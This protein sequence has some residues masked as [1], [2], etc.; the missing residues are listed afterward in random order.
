MHAI[1]ATVSIRLDVTSKE[2]MRRVGR[3]AGLEGAREMPAPPGG[4]R[5][6]R[7]S[8]EL[9]ARTR[10]SV[11]FL[12]LS[13]SLY[14][15]ILL[16]LSLASLPLQP[17]EPAFLLRDTFTRVPRCVRARNVYSSA[18]AIRP[19]GDETRPPIKT[20]RIACTRLPLSRGCVSFT[21]SR[22]RSAAT[23]DLSQVE[24]PLHSVPS[25]SWTKRASFSVVSRIKFHWT[26]VFDSIISG[27]Y[28]RD[29][30]SF[31]YFFTVI[32]G[33]LYLISSG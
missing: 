31:W 18:R 6:Y 8:R 1:R 32:L 24:K 30:Y 33:V 10:A 22:H 25:S 4:A 27:K 19:H 21:A 15:S 17:A 13:I 9:R 11:H 7:R 3:V 16:S 14:L 12:S 29:F 5:F 28:R 23:S 26:F 20:R 2:W